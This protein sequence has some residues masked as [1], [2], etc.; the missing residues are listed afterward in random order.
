MGQAPDDHAERASG[1]RCIVSIVPRS[2]ARS[3]RPSF[4]LTISTASAVGATA[5]ASDRPE[6]YETHNPPFVQ[7]DVSSTASSAPPPATA[8]ATST[9]TATADPTAS[10]AAPVTK[11]PLSQG[12]VVRLAHDKTCFVYQPFPPLRP[13]EQRPPGTEPPRKKVPCPAG[14]ESEPSYLDCLEG[15]VLASGDP[16]S[17]VCAV[18]GNPPPPPRPVV[19]PK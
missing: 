4:V 11:N 7:L 9:A 19:C 12:A 16:P 2:R 15:A 18:G 8:T 1:R 14:M 13:N 10:A 5:C 6:I 3:L 17:C